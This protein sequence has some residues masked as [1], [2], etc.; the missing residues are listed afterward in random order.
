MSVRFAKHWFTASEYERMGEAG[1]LPANERFELIE[2]EIIKM[3]PIGKRHAACVN[4]LS[5]ILNR[6][7]SNAVIVS[8]Q[9]PIV[10][11]DFSEPQPDVALLKFREDFYEHALPQSTDVLLVIEVSDTT[12]DYD[13]KIKL[14]SYAHA[15]IAEVWIVNL[16]E[17][18]IET[19]AQ[20]ANGTYEHTWLLKHGE[21]FTSETVPDLKINVDAVLG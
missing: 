1:I 6:Q 17:E 7:V 13:R 15:S 20:P 10:L 21:T 12:L 16:P 9:N 8:I 14:S 3:S 11:D 18:I 19:Y 2:G 4:R 5:R